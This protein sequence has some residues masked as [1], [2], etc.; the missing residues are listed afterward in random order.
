MEDS[1]IRG[2]DNPFTLLEKNDWFYTVLII[3]YKY[4]IISTEESKTYDPN[5]FITRAEFIKLFYDTLIRE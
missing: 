4:G 2:I 3:A 1:D 5:A